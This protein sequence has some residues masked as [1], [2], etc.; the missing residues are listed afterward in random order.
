MDENANRSKTFSNLLLPGVQVRQINTSLLH[1]NTP[2]NQSSDCEITE[3]AA[4][5][6]N[7][8]RQPA[9]APGVSRWQPIIHGRECSEQRKYNGKGSPC[10]VMEHCQVV[11]VGFLLTIE[12]AQQLR[13]P[14]VEDH[15]PLSGEPIRSEI[16]IQFG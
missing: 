9:S 3:C 2:I 16:E 12:A 5:G 6:Q 10:G 1:H 15:L 8:H 4:S 7:Q 11:H 13:G 14:P